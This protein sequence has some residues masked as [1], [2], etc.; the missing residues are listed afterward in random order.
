MFLE[1]HEDLKIFLGVSWSSQYLIFELFAVLLGWVGVENGIDIS[2]IAI[3]HHARLKIICF[4]INHNTTI[5]IY[6]FISIILTIATDITMAVCVVIKKQ[7]EY[8]DGTLG[9]HNGTLN[10]IT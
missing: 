6:V 2:K 3:I 4:N 10:N 8:I 1:S 5:D 7:V 9:K